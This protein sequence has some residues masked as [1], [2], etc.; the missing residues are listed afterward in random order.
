M[1]ENISIELRCSKT[2]DGKYTAHTFANGKQVKDPELSVNRSDEYAVVLLYR[3]V[4][5]KYPK[6]EIAVKGLDKH[7]M[8]EIARSQA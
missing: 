1:P 4:K 8:D 3:R 7:A 5:K 6:V 2:S